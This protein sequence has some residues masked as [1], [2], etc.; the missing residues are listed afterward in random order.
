MEAQPAARSRTHSPEASFLILLLTLLAFGL[1]VYRLDHHS[2]W[3]DEGFSVYVARQGLSQITSTVAGDYTPPLH[4]YLLHFWMGASGDSEFSVRFLSV[5]SGSWLVPLTYVLA[6]RLVGLQSALWA[7]LWVSV[8][9]FL[10][11]YSQEARAY[12]L[13]AALGLLTSYL[14]IRLVIHPDQPR[15]WAAYIVGGILALYSHLYAFFGLAIQ[16]A[17]FFGVVTLLRRRLGPTLTGAVA[18]SVILAAY[19]PWAEYTLRAA[20]DTSGYFPGVLQP[21]YMLR[22]SA[23]AFSTGDLL[24]EDQRGPIAGLYVALALA[25]ASLLLLQ[26][27]GRL[28]GSRPSLPGGRLYLLAQ[29]VLPLAWVSV[30]LYQRP[31]FFPR[32]LIASAPFFFMLVGVALDALWSARS[33][34]REGLNTGARILG[35]VLAGTLLATSWWGLS[36]N[37]FDERYARDD[38]RSAIAYLQERIAPQEEILL[39]SGHFFPVFAYYYQGDNW[40]PIPDDFLLDA[41]HVIGFEVNPE[42]DRILAGK[43]G[44]W[45]VQWQDHIVDPMGTLRLLLEAHGELIDARWQPRGP[46]LYRYGLPPNV[47]IAD[48]PPIAQPMQINFGNR[49]RLLGYS[50]PKYG[51]AGVVEVILFWE[52]LRPLNE[53]YKVSLRLV[54]EAEH[55][56]ALSDGWPATV[57][58]P[59]LRWPPFRVVFGRHRI[60]PLVGTPPGEYWVDVVVYENNTLV[61]LEVLDERGSPVGT[62]ARIGPFSLSPT[63]QLVTLEDVANEIQTSLQ[64][65]FGDALELVGYNWEPRPVSTGEIIQFTLLWRAL[66]DMDQD[67]SVVFPLVDRRGMLHAQLGEPSPGAVGRAIFAGDGEFLGRLIDISEPIGRQRIVIDSDTRKSFSLYPLGSPGYP[68]SAWREGEVVQ[69]Q[70]SYRVPED[71]PSGPHQLRIQLVGPEGQPGVTAVLFPID[72]VRGGR[73]GGHIPFTPYTVE[74]LGMNISLEGYNLYPFS[75]MPGGETQLTLFWQI[76]GGAASPFGLRIRLIDEQGDT[77]FEQEYPLPTSVRSWVDLAVGEGFAEVYRIVI[78]EE[79]EPGFYHLVLSVYE[80]ISGESLQVAFQEIG[81]GLSRADRFM[82]PTPLYIVG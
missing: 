12:S 74:P 10:A 80:P 82:L 76:D 32:H 50:L 56:Y 5:I 6:R 23:T 48:G 70:Y 79:I 8:S 81:G 58:Y 9:P 40:H 65:A 62:S 14:L 7:T 43:R 39:S 55:Q 64:V 2:L 16:A 34:L 13:L 17:Y 30:A 29:L 77:L 15:L 47:R 31:Q 73:M 45:L 63:E 72:I 67:Y 57:G 61:P 71:A 52:G 46:V 59:T 37:Y 26:E 18:F 51:E 21:A 24:P 60:A 27:L 11:W 75:L 49:L 53:D 1:R 44:V 38:F 25:G 33:P 54:D 66:R 36:N 3:Y 35:A 68:T 42:L 78:P 28:A 69:A 22:V 19:L 20:Q 4:Y 41:D